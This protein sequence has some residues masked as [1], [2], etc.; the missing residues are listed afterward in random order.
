MATKKAKKTVTAVS[1]AHLSSAVSVQNIGALLRRPVGMSL[2]IGLNRVDP[3]HYGGWSGALTA[4]EADANDMQAIAVSK[5]Y[6]TTKRLTTTA[7]SA[8]VMNDIRAAASRLRSGD[9]FLL[10]YSGHGGQTPDTNGDEAGFSSDGK[11]ETWVLF[12]R[13]VVDDEL[14]NLFGTFAAGVRIFVLSDSC[15]SGTVTREMLQP[16]IPGARLMPPDVADK[17]YKKNKKLYDEIQSLNP[18]MTRAAVLSSVLLISG[19]Q[20]N[21]VSMDGPRNGLFTGKLRTVWN[22]GTFRG[23]Y[24]QF[25]DRIAALMPATQSP[26][27]FKAGAANATFE[28]QNPFTI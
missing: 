13:Q 18:P 27:Y 24:R 5:G 3:A 8:V 26:N 12:D 6:T 21:Q 2:H 22:N 23:T 11:D 20:D 14:Y 16:P 25:R 10:T 4:C 17:T 1:A 9:I 7:T 19:C 15:H 28:A